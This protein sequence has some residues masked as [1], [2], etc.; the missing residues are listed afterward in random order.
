MAA[1]RKSDGKRSGTPFHQSRE[2]AAMLPQDNR[3]Q[4]RK[5]NGRVYSTIHWIGAVVKPVVP[6]FES[7]RFR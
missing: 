2:S 3:R 6:G 5:D 1:W 7:A 4:H